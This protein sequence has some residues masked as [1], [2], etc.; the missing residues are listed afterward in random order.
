MDLG[1]R[2][3]QW[4]KWK[5]WNQKQL[6]EAASVSRALICQIEGAGEY[7]SSPSQES[8]AAIVE[9]LGISF[10]RFYGKL[11]ALKKRAA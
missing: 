10:S 1:P 7:H 5:G 6:A 4:R 3:R 11:P 8:L 2:I 9:A